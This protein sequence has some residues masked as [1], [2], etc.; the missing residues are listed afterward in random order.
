MDNISFDYIKSV[1]CGIIMPDLSVVV[2][3]DPSVTRQR[4]KGKDIT[5]LARQEQ[6]EGYDRYLK[7]RSELV[8]MFGN[9]HFYSNNTLEDGDKIVKSIIKQIEVDRG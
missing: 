3:A 8:E 7:Y 9:V 1:N 5:R 4:L 2:S 6:V